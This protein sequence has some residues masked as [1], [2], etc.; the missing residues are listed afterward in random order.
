MR[1]RTGVFAMH[2]LPART[3]VVPAFTEPPCVTRHTRSSCWSRDHRRG[4]HWCGCPGPNSVESQQSHTRTDP[5]E[6]HVLR[7]ERGP[8]PLGQPA[9]GR[10]PHREHRG[11]RRDG[12]RGRRRRAV[13]GGAGHGGPDAAWWET[14]AAGPGRPRGLP[15]WV[16]GPLSPADR[17]RAPGRGPTAYPRYASRPGGATRGFLP[18]PPLAGTDTRINEAVPGPVTRRTG[19]TRPERGCGRTAFPGRAAFLGRAAFRTGVTP[20]RGTAPAA[21]WRGRCPACRRRRCSG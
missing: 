20:G 11:P 15:H 12:R 9:G 21:S 8:R 18:M 4:G 5:E 6:G 10:L 1:R 7:P 13:R 19:E 2:D 16:T 17:S 14:K 3:T